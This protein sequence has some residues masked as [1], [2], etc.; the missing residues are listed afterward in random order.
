ME[1]TKRY[2]GIIVKCNNEVLLCKRNKVGSHAGE[3][4]IPCGQL[5]KTENAKLGAIREFKEET[6]LDIDDITLV[7]FINRT[8]RDGSKVKGLMYVFMCE[9]DERMNPDLENAMDGEEHTECGY[10]TKENLPTPIGGDLKQLIEKVVF[11][12]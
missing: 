3:W 8:N 7:G 1:S 12:D 11:V 5:N 10:F 9:V 6:N 2:G 4:S